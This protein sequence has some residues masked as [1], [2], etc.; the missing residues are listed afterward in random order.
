L[1]K[2]VICSAKS[3]LSQANHILTVAYPS[4]SPGLPSPAPVTTTKDIWSE[5]LEIT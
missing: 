5:T 2:A 4:Y 3:C 1:K